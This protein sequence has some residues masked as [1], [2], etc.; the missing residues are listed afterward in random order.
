MQNDFHTHSNFQQSSTCWINSPLPHNLG[1]C[2][3]CIQ[4]HIIAQMP[5]AQPVPFTLPSPHTPKVPTL[6]NPS[7]THQVTGCPVHHYIIR[8]CLNQAGPLEAFRK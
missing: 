2:P 1:T 8:P 6:P 3:S 5:G 7:V 4:L